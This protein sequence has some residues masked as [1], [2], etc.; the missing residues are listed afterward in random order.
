MDNK[1]TTQETAPGARLVEMRSV[2]D[3][4]TGKTVKRHTGNANLFLTDEGLIEEWPTRKMVKQT[5]HLISKRRDKGNRSR[6]RGES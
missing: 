2:K 3:P 6:R 1:T 4:I 5:V